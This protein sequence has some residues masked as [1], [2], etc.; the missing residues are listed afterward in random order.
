MMFTS[1]NDT[2][3][4]DDDTPKIPSPVDDCLM[5]PQARRYLMQSGYQSAHFEFEVINLTASIP[6]D[7]RKKVS[8]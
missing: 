5:S 4:S 2:I 7:N 1:M 8:K 6:A 3:Y